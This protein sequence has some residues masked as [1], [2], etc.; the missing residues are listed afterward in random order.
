MALK[1]C[2]DCGTL[3]P[4]ARCPPHRKAKD[5]ARSARRG[6]TAQR[7]LTGVHAAMSRYYKSTDAPC[8]IC[9][10]RGTPANPIT[11]GHI[12]A[13]SKGGTNDPANYQ[14]ECRSCGSKK[15]DN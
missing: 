15:Q 6:T 11:A 4:E 5:N 10:R 8:V 3:S 7:G 12:I 14:P 1:P 2:L 13:R 9:G